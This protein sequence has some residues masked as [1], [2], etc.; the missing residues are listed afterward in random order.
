MSSGSTASLLLG[1]A[2][3]AASVKIA[4]TVWLLHQRRVGRQAAADEALWY[5]G[6]FSALLL[7]AACIARA[8][9][10]GDQPTFWGLALLGSVVTPVALVMMRRRRAQAPG[11][12]RDAHSHV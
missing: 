3:A 4:C 6:K 8:W 5:A 2:V 9:L 12:R 10:L 7:L 1:L 11:A